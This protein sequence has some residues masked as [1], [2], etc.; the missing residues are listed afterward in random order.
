MFGVYSNQRLTENESKI[1]K[2]NPDDYNWYCV[3]VQSIFKDERFFQVREDIELPQDD[4]DNG[5]VLIFEG[6]DVVY[7]KSIDDEVTDEKLESI[8]N[9]CR[10]LE[11][12]FN[13]PINAYVPCTPFKD[14]DLKFK[15]DVGNVTIFFS[16]INTQNA[17]LLIDKLSEK[18]Q[19]DEAFTVSDSIDHMLIPYTSYRDKKVF[20]EKYQQY[21]KLVD[22]YVERNKF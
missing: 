14:L 9:V 7:L 10:F 22:E 17:E 5:V 6:G 15:T 12:K 21:M 1:L 20:D 8:Y 19:N 4:D 16:H 3:I 11:D 2:H 13:R 18:L